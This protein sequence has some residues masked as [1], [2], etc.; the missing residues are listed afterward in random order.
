MKNHPLMNDVTQSVIRWLGRTQGT[1]LCG[2][3]D[4][5]T[6]RSNGCQFQLAFPYGRRRNPTKLI[7]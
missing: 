5:Y 7:T 1:G 6:H 2:R 3:I 4:W